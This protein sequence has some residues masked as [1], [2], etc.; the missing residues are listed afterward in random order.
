MPVVAGRRRTCV[1]RWVDMRSEPRRQSGLPHHGHVVGWR[2]VE[3]CLHHYKAWEAEG[4]AALLRGPDQPH[5]LHASQYL[6]LKS[7]CVLWCCRIAVSAEPRGGRVIILYVAL[8]EVKWHDCRLLII[9]RTG[10]LS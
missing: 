9:S 7:V 3:A 8:G 5:P 10:D 4:L 6:K 1:S 2:R